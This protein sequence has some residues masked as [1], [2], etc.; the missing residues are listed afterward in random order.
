MHPLD[1]PRLKVERATEHLHALDEELGTF[2]DSEPVSITAGFDAK[3]GR[4]IY[5]LEVKLPPPLRLGLTAADA[6]YNLRSALDL[7]AWQL[8]L[9]TTNTPFKRTEFP[10]CK[11]GTIDNLKRM[12]TITKSIPDGARDIIDSL[13]PYHRGSTAELHP[14]WILDAL[15]NLSKHRVIPTRA[16]VGTLKVPA[17]PGIIEQQLNDRT[18]VVSVPGQQDF[19]PRAGAGVTFGD[20]SSG[21]SVHSTDLGNIHNFV[22]DDVIPRFTGFFP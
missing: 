17:I 2:Y 19:K 20:R 1:G 15:C 8:V 7:L 21:M 14:L 5:R 22:R 10:I 16:T 3:N 4:N 9:L 13:Q 12:A 6:V 11:D 18:I